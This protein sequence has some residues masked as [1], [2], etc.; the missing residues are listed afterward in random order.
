MLEALRAQL[1]ARAIALGH[2]R[3]SSAQGATLYDAPHD[4]E[5]R[6]SY[7]EYANRNPWFLSSDDYTAQRVMTGEE[8]INNRELMR[9][10]FYRAVLKPR[11][12][13]HQLCGVLARRGDLVYFVAAHRGEDQE[14]FGE[15]DKASLRPLLAHLCLALENHWRCLQAEDHSRALARIVDQDTRATMLLT[16]SGRVIYRNKRALALAEHSSGLRVDDDQLRA[17]TAVDN[18]ALNEALVEVAR[19]GMLDDLE[20]P[21]V[22]TISAPE[23]QSP[24]VVVL[25]PAGSAFLAEIGQP[26]P[27]VL[28]TLRS[29]HAEH[30]PHTCPLA[31]R[32]ELT[33]AQARVS[34]MVFSGHNLGDISSTLHVSE[35]TVRSHLKQIFQKT[36][37][38]GQMEL[39][40]LHARLCVGD[41]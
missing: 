11:G 23:G 12:L 1:R 31:H 36:N 2:F 25:R 24:S 28:L 7:A 22:V 18:R 9:T 16:A 14:S 37:T 33:P 41:S 26:Q 17:A 8:L 30:D 19:S 40:H 5:F 13:L 4:P 38:H 29:A 39:V 35:N 3:F 27:L 32:Y 34:A 15:K 21:R 10:D 20:N 6:A